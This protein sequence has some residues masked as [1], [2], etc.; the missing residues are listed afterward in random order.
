MLE[1]GIEQLE[2]PIRREHGNALLQIVERFSLNLDQGVVTAFEREPLRYVVV[3]IGD[4]P[5]RALLGNDVQHAPVRQMPPVLEFARRP[6]TGQQLCFP[7]PVIDH[8]GEAGGLTQPVEDFTVR[9]LRR[10]P[11]RIEL[12]EPLVGAVEKPEPLVGSEN[13]HCRRD[14]V[15]RAIIRGD[16]PV[17]LALG[18]LDGCYIDG[19]GSRRVFKRHDDNIVRLALAAHDQR[20]PFRDARATGEAR[21][22]CRALTRFQ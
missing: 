4:A 7:C 6:I 2:A 19:S 22:E 8:G 13:C 10:Q 12:P 11:I 16:L 15:Q 9:R 1:R 5:I 14:P 21:L 17:E 18:G 3:E 20:H